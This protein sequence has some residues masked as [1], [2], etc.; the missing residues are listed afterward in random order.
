VA[1]TAQEYAKS[2]NQFAEAMTA[3]RASFDQV[4]GKA[5]SL[6]LATNELAAR[7][8]EATDKMIAARDQT[9]KDIVQNAQDRV[10]VATGGD[11]FERQMQVFFRDQ[12]AQRRAAADQVR[13][14]GVGEDQVNRVLQALLD[15]AGAEAT[16]KVEA[17][18]QQVQMTSLSSRY[19]ALS[20]LSS[21]G[22]ILTSFLD[23]QAVADAGPQQQFIA[24]Q[25]AYRKQ[26]EQ[27]SRAGAQ[28]ADLSSVTGAAESLLSATSSFYGDGQEAALIKAGVNNQIRALGGDL[29]LAGFGGDIE[30]SV[31]KWIASN[32]SSTAAIDRLT[33]RIMRLEDELRITRLTAIDSPS[34]RSPDMLTRAG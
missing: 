9:L 29:G 28:D 25:E 13:Q 6:G 22:N 11:T 33:D 24:A 15:A 8:Q 3:L 21:Q 4:I 31:D 23:R 14:L 34:V 10:L 19:D 1:K 16:A 18:R 7:Q 20:G 5:K 2:H 30:K 17:D 12:D 32:S 27:A 26:L